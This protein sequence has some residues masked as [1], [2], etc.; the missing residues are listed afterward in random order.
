[1]AGE[2]KGRAALAP[3]QAFQEHHIPAAEEHSLSQPPGPT[4]K[5]FVMAALA[6]DPG[7]QIQRG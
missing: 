6:S 4:A 2:H 1:M 7:E 5:L 3:F